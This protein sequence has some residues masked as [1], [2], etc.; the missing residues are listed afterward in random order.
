MY[1]ISVELPVSKNIFADVKN[2]RSPPGAWKEVTIIEK[3][4]EKYLLKLIY[5]NNSFFGS[6]F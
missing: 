5:F 4:P 2:I 3:T 6:H 1:V